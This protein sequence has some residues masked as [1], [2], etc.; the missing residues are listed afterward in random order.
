MPDAAEQAVRK[1]YCRGK[2]PRAVARAAFTLIDVLVTMAVV[3]LLLG[4]LM[5]GFA[6]VRETSR[7]VVCASNLRQ[8]GFGLTLYADTNRDYLPSS[9][10]LRGEKPGGEGGASGSE[11][12]YP[13]EMM[14]LRLPG[15]PIYGIDKT[16]DGLG[17]LYSN[18]FLPTP[19]IFYCPSHWGKHP[20][21][22]YV[23]YWKGQNGAIVGNYHFRGVGPN[24]SRRLSR[25]EPS[26]AA[27]VTDGLKTRLDFNHKVGL[28][29]LRAD[30]SLSWLSDGGR[31]YEYLPADGDSSLRAE[32]FEML[33]EQIDHPDSDVLP[34]NGN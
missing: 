13:S 8:I 10:F 23:P 34:D 24:G 28:N 3:A 9:A 2:P 11:T 5:P 4:I 1:S 12:W 7:R 18:E 26:R 14:T 33:W 22:R 29:V 19:E 21:S 16:W 31:L 27:I 20:L 25:I 30:I 32:D 17:M 15:L 6:S